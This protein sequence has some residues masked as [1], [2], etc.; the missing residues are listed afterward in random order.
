MYIRMRIHIYIRMYLCM[1]MHMYIHRYV[2][3]IFYDL[4]AIGVQSQSIS[5]YMPVVCT[6]VCM[7]SRS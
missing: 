7:Y 2:G 5:I 1:Y 6:Y 4:F 3:P